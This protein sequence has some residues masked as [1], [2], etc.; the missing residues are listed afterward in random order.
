MGVS[1]T[2][3]HKPP[4]GPRVVLAGEKN[5][6]FFFVI[7]MNLSESSEEKIISKMGWL[8]ETAS[9]QMGRSFGNET[10]ATQAQSIEQ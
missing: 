7:E 1:G 10:H 8:S 6:S 5:K 4:T 3:N 2:A 9:F